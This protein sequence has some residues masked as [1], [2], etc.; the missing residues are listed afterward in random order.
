[1]EKL[2]LSGSPHIKAPR[3]T[4]SIMID[5]CVALLPATVVGIVFF[6]LNALITMIISVVGAFAAE[7]IWK[8]AFMRK[9]FR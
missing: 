3:T 1:M 5:V 8:M 6:G 4:K 7:L 2:V 9:N